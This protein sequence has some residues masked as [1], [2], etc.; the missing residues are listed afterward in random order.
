VR[1]WGSCA[2]AKTSEQ[3][4]PRYVDLGQ[5]LLASVTA[6]SAL[7]VERFWDPARERWDMGKVTVTR[8]NKRGV[9][10]I[11][12]GLLEQ[13]A[14]DS[15]SALSFGHG[16]SIGNVLFGLGAAGSAYYAARRFK[17]LGA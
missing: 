11:P 4:I 1:L 14:R 6:Y 7:L 17:L 15:Q 10:V 8:P 9:L 3:Q 16:V 5:P 12:K 13:T 2:G